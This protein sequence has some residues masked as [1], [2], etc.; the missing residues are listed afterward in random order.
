MFDLYYKKNDNLDLFK[1]I[2]DIGI[3]GVQNYIPLY[4]QYFSLKSTNYRNMNLNHHY[5]IHEVLATH[6][7]NKFLCKIKSDKKT[8]QQKSFFKFSPL[9]DPVKYMVGKYKDLGENES[10]LLP[11]LENNKCHKKISDVNNS[12]YVDSFFSYLTSQILNKSYFP[13]GLDFYGSFLGIQKEFLYNIADDIEY[14]HESTYFHKNQNEKFKIENIDLSMIVDENTR[15][16]KKKLNIGKNISNKSISSISNENY[17]DVFHLSDISLNDKEDVD[18]I[19]EFNLPK[20]ESRK[21]NSTCSSRSSNTESSEIIIDGSDEENEY[22]KEDTS[23]NESESD[24]ETESDDVSMDSEIEVNTILYNYPV[25][26]ICLECLDNTLDSLL[27]EDLMNAEQW[28]ACLLQIIMTLIVYQKVFD[29]THNDLH[30]N[31]IMFSKTDKQFLYYRYNQKYYK[32]PTFGRIFKII[33]FGRA[34]YKFKGKIMCSDSYHKNGDAATQYNCEPYFNPKKPRLEPNPSFDLC[35]LAC[36]LFDYFID[37]VD[38]IEPTDVIA[39]IVL[40]W[41]K[42]DKGRN[43]LYK[44]NGDERYPEFKL[45][46][47]IARTVHKHTPQAQL[48]GPLFNKYL[49]TRKKFGRKTKFVD[50]DTMPVLT[51]A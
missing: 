22:Q 14:L 21:T 27:E 44:K 1:S 49:V 25:Q 37:D 30:T 18:L 8:L 13:N 9:L 29:F 17:D 7:R 20:N 26:V 33:D 45:Y 16:Y 11:S 41:T 23:D 10:T 42:D 34:I 47:M 31:N 3:S 15:N 4:K 43:I 19:F 48:K 35:R 28:R 6:K 12:A 51:K 40:E 46:K 50:I 38:C 2:E 36:S 32:V 24:Y 39:N 5:H